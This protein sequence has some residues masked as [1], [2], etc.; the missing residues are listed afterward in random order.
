M[1]LRRVLVALVR[2]HLERADE[3]RARVLGADDLV[4]V[5]ELGGLERVGE[6]LPV[7]GRETLALGLG[8]LRLLD[9]VAEDDVDGAVR[10]MTAISAVG[11]RGSRRRGCAWRT[12]RRTRRRRPCA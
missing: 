6:L 12:S 4:D 7:V 5:S 9:L 1:L 11:R 3:T 8:L 10:P 2:E